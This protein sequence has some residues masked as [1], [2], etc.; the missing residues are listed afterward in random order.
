[1]TMTEKAADA[2]L[3]QTTE[4]DIRNKTVWVLTRINS[5]NSLPGSCPESDHAP[6]MTALRGSFGPTGP[7]CK[8]CSG[9]FR[10]LCL[11]LNIQCLSVWGS[12]STQ[13]DVLRSWNY[14]R[15]KDGVW[16]AVDVT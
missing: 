2:S 13:P 16:Y 4:G 5:C 12:I 14:V 6:S 10:P 8:A 7:V 9:T 3:Q 11:R 1:M 15:R